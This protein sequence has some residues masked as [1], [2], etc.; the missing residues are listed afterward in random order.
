MFVANPITI[1]LYRT[2][3][4][5]ITSPTAPAN[6]TAKPRPG[7]RRRHAHQISNLV[8]CEQHVGCGGLCRILVEMAKAFF[9]SS[10]RILE[11][12][13]RSGICRDD[14]RDIGMGPVGCPA[15]VLIP[16]VIAADATRGL[17]LGGVDE[18]AKKPAQFDGGSVGAG[19]H[20][21]G[22]VQRD[23]LHFQ[24][25]PSNCRSLRGGSTDRTPSSTAVMSATT[26]VALL[27]RRRRERPR[28]AP[29][30]RWATRLPG[31]ARAARRVGDRMG[32]VGRCR[33]Q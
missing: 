28:P 19:M 13:G 27:R 22:Q 6:E 30:R 16:D 18:V 25:R 33:A 23:R 4:A 14:D 5:A 21:G 24:A 20:F 9:L 2:R 7:C 31:V 3:P 11:P 15:R 8:T 26:S 29:L 12:C 10:W 17:R 1:R 32:G